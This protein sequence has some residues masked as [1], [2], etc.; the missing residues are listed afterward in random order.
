MDW[1]NRIKDKL[2][3]IGDKARRI[4]NRILGR[5]TTSWKNSTLK[6]ETEGVTL[7]RDDP[8]L[9]WQLGAT[10]KH[11]T[12]CAFLN[13]QIKRASEWRAAGIKPQSPDLECGGWNCD[14]RLVVVD[15]PD[16]A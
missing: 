1:A 12:D 13:G 7:N 2:A 4:G 14:C 16:G 5:I 3:A 6:F 10:E 15:K 9:E 8:Y 11:C